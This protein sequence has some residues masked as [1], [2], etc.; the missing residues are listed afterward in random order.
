M[1]VISHTLETG[2]VVYGTDRNDGTGPIIKKTGFRPSQNLAEHPEYGSAYWYVASTRRRRAKTDYIDRC[3]AALRDAGHQIRVEIDNTTLPTTSFAQLEQERYERAEERAD[4]FT[5]FADNAAA[6]GTRAIEQVDQD[7]KQIPLGQPHL[8]GHHSY[9][10]TV[11]QEQQRNAREQRGL[12]H[13]RRGRRWRQRADA[14]ERFQSGRQAIGTTQRRIERLEAEIRAHDR[15]LAGRLEHWEITITTGSTGEYGI[16][17]DERLARRPPGSHVLSLDEGR[18][19]A[20][21]LIAVGPQARAEIQAQIT[22]LTEEV[23]YW[24]NHVAALQADQG[25]KVWSKSDFVRGDLIQCGGQRWYEIVRVNPKT[26]SVANGVNSVDLKVVTRFNARSA[27]GGPGWTDKLPYH[28][29]TDQMDAAEARTRFPD[30][31]SAAD[32]A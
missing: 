25:M 32:P 21:V 28:Q 13:V 18:N 5:T 23:D 7:R 1:L 4:R 24:R 22:L 6:Q 10:K 15:F 30:A 12:E 17:L 29:V 2:T 3:A 8:I 9:N 11:R 16:S 14:A 19:V 31:F 26:L 27:T 20:E